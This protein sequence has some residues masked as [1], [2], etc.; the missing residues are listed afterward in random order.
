VNT[1][2][3]ATSNYDFKYI[4]GLDSSTSDFL[5]LYTERPIYRPGDTVFFK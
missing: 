3:D 4:S 1:S 5:Y 2:N